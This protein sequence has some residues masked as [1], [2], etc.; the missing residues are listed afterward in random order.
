MMKSYRRSLSITLLVFLLNMTP[1][2]FTY[3]QKV[4]S[5]PP[6]ISFA[7]LDTLGAATTT[8]QFSSLSAGGQGLTTTHHPGARFTVGQQTLITEIGGFV[9]SCNQFVGGGPPCSPL[10]P[11]KVEIRAEVNGLPDLF[12]VMAGFALSNDNNNLLISYESVQPNLVLQPGTYYAMFAPQNEDQGLLMGV[13]NDPFFYLAEQLTLG[14]LDPIGHTAS[15]GPANVAVRILGTSETVANFCLQDDGNRQVL[16]LDTLTGAYQLVACNGFSLAGQ[17]TIRR[18]GSIVTL[19]DNSSGRRLV[20]SI[21][22]ATH[23]GNASLQLLG[24]QRF[25]I[26]DRDTRNNSCLC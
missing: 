15:T 18:K 16:F 23:K 14:S 9:E 17:G 20:A 5:A 1:L 6:Q 13:A 21:D 10:V 11:A 3:Q 24:G 7:I 25:T 22:L 19:Q 12:N 26:M 8:T 4:Q 2:F